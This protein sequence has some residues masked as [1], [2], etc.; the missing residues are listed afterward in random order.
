VHAVLVEGTI[1]RQDGHDVVDPGGVL[2]GRVLRG[3]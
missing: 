3:S 1:V 2:P